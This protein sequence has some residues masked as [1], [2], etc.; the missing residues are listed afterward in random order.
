MSRA[1]LL[2][3]RSELK[4]VADPNKALGMQAYMKSTMPYHGVPTPLARKV[5]RKVFASLHFEN[6]DSW[7][8]TVLHI[9]RHA[10]PYGTGD[11]TPS[12]PAVRIMRKQPPGI[13]SGGRRARAAKGTRWTPLRCFRSDRR[14]PCRATGRRF[15]ERTAQCGIPTGRRE[16]IR[17][18][19]QWT[20]NARTSARDRRSRSIRIKPQ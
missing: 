19:N 18:V 2:Q 3:L 15:A 11:D 9:W 10:L 12:S 8:D 14:S 1:L 7:R 16:H 20:G 17:E 4:Q 13:R 5:F 6:A